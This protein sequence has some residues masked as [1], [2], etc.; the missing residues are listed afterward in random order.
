MALQEII[1][2]AWAKP[3]K[4]LKAKVSMALQ[5]VSDILLVEEMRRNTCGD[6][7]ALGSDRRDSND[8]VASS[9]PYSRDTCQCR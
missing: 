7:G 9:I 6:C 8:D 4:T 3:S 5:Q 2:T 1:D